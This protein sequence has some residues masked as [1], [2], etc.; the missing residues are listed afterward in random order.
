MTWLT[1]RLDLLKPKSKVNQ[2]YISTGDQSGI[3]NSVLGVG[4]ADFAND[5]F[6]TLLSPLDQ[7]DSVTLLSNVLPNGSVLRQANDRAGISVSYAAGQF[8]FK[9]GTTGD[10]SSLKIET[11]STNGISLLGMTEDSPSFEVKPQVSLVN[12]LPAVR[13]KA[14]SPAIVNG[15]PMGVDPSRSF[16]VTQDNKTLTVIVDGISAQIEPT[17]GSY[18]IGTFTPTPRR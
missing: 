6:G 4:E 12:N 2:L 18:S 17:Q 7:D 5:S 8:S 11:P 1:K 10:G 13:G 3:N 16:E 9:S 15:S 14:S